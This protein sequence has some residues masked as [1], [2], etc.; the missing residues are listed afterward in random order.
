MSLYVQVRFIPLG[1]I[2]QCLVAR[3]VTAESPVQL[4]LRM[5]EYDD[6]D[7]VRD[8]QD[9]GTRFGTI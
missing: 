6:P 7:R 3:S 8:Y 5:F 1:A 2:F 9:R 4:R